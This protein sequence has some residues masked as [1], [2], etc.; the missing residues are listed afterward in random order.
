MYAVKNQP[1]AEQRSPIATR[2]SG[3]VKATWTKEPS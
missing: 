1:L 2:P 3:A